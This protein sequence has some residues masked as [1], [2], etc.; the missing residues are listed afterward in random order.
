MRTILAVLAFVCAGCGATAT[1]DGLERLPDGGEIA[2]PAGTVLG[3]NQDAGTVIVATGD[4]GIIEAAPCDGQPLPDGGSCGAQNCIGLHEQVTDGGLDCCP[5][6]GP[7]TVQGG[8][9]YFYPM[10]FPG[11]AC[12]AAG[13]TATFADEQCCGPGLLHCAGS[14]TCIAAATCVEDAG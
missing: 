12:I 6:T 13:A 1:P 2:M 10:C 8:P 14:N 3:I 4:G 9:N 11:G 7:V 5:G